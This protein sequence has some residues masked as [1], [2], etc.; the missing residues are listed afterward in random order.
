MDV[1]CIHSLIEKRVEGS[2]VIPTGFEPVAYRLG[3]CRSI[4]LSYGTIRSDILFFAA[5]AK[6]Q[7]ERKFLQSRDNQDDGGRALSASCTQ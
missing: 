1:S 2:M 7:D 4:L 5:D 6:S 3:I